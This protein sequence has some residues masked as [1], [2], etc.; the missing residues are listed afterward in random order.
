MSFETFMYWFSGVMAFLLCA[1]LA[2]SHVSAFPRVFTDSDISPA[3]VYY[4]LSKIRSEYVN[5][6]SWIFI[7]HFCPNSNYDAWAWYGSRSITF[8]AD[9]TYNLQDFPWLLR[10]EMGHLYASQHKMY[11]NTSYEERETIATRVA[12]EMNI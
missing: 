7:R 8:C 11:F 9:K 12:E 1:I 4:E 6:T 2:A 5:S 3:L 10:H